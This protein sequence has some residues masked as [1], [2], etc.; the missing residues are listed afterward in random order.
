[1][2]TTTIIPSIGQL[3]NFVG[4]LN[5]KIKTDYEFVTFIPN[6]NSYQIID[7]NQCFIN[8]T[9][10]P[11]KLD[12]QP[13]SN[14]LYTPETCM[15][16]AGNRQ[17]ALNGTHG[18]TAVARQI[19]SGLHFKVYSGYFN[20]NIDFFKTASP[21]TKN[22]YSDVSGV[23]IDLTD[24]ATATN[25]YI[26]MPNNYFHQYSVQWYGYFVANVTGYWQFATTSDDASYLWLGYDISTGGNTRENATVNVGG[27]HP[28]VRNL[29]SLI[30]FVKGQSVPIIIQFGENNGNHN[31]SL[32]IIDPTGVITH[33]SS[34]LFTSQQDDNLKPLVYFALKENTPE[35]TA[36]NMFQCLITDNTTTESKNQ[37]N[38]YSNNNYAEHSI[39]NPT[40][41]S[42]NVDTLK[43]DGRIVGLYDQNGNLIFVINS[44]TGSDDSS[45]TPGNNDVIIFGNGSN[46]PQ[47]IFDVARAGDVC[48]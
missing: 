30:Y 11:T 23:T 20:D 3:Q 48:V 2:S 25:H 44:V 22:E 4:S 42:S 19:Q 21:D 10:Q 37:L 13:I 17:A 32:D 6:A 46:C 43:Y 33:G 5:N 41:A 47:T 28:L 36:K 18:T 31:F 9:L 15:V 1:M 29:S 38:N 39:W 34:Y 26:P 40:H 45:V 14:N 27:L 16:N 12:M 24:I 35:D 7:N 8:S